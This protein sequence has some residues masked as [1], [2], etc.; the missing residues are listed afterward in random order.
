MKKC[1]W[2]DGE[3]EPKALTALWPQTVGR[4]DGDKTKLWRK[5]QKVQVV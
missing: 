2:E 5:G 3:V 1:A 4:S